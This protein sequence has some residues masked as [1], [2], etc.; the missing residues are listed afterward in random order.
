MPKERSR[1]VRIAIR[2]VFLDWDPIGIR[3]EPNAQDEYDGYIGHAF[4]LLATG[5]TDREIEEYLLWIV[6]RMGMDGSRV[7][8]RD[9]ITA[10]RAIRLDDDIGVVKQP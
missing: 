6:N 9:V 8:H 7:S 5:A 10:L 3:D 2:R 1:E 4:E